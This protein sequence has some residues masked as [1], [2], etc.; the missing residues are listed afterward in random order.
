MKYLFSVL[1]FIII[2]I[3]FSSCTDSEKSYQVINNSVNLGREGKVITKDSVVCTVTGQYWNTEDSQV[4]SLIVLKIIN[5]SG[6]DLTINKNNIS[7]ASARTTMEKLN[8]NKDRYE[9]PDGGEQS[10]IIHFRSK[11]AVINSNGRNLLPADEVLTLKLTALFPNS[12]ST[13]IAD[14]K[15]IP[16]L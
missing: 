4:L 15:L 9:V 14:V 8:F 13:S 1:S 7:L 3:H 11:T 16:E 2:C 12:D 5:Y 10:I 6:R